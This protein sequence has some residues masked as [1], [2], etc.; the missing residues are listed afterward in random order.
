M[1]APSKL[2]PV[3]PDHVPTDLVFDFDIYADPRIDSD[4]QGSYQRAI[5]GAPDIFWTPANGGHWMVQRMDSI[6]AITTDPEHFSVREMQIPRVEN[7]PFMI[8]LSL[9]PPENLPYRRAMSPMFGPKA[10]KALEP[11]LRYWAEKIVDS[12]ADK[13][14]CD[15]MAEVAKIYPVSIFMELMGMDLARLPEFRDLAERFFDAQNNSAL[16]DQLS[17]QI[18]GILSEL[19][20]EKRK[21]PDEQLMSHFVHVD[22]GEGKPMSDNEILAMSFVLFLGGMDTVTNVTGFAFQQL[23]QMPDLQKPMAADPAGLSTAFADEAV[24][25]FGVINTPRLVVKDIDL[26]GVPFRTG[27]MVLN[28]LPVGSRDDR[29][30]E[31][32]NLLDIDRK[33]AAHI[34]FSTGPHLCIG[35]VLGRAE[36]RVMAEEWFKRIPSFELVPDSERTF[37]TGTVM[38]LENLPL[39][40]DS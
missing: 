33:R 31:H 13:G 7:P 12:V 32:P 25:A 28:V 19:I 4:V 30:F 22:M 10:I 2:A 21:N 23:A 37:R 15:F 29:K 5:N 17:A 40:W 26:L 36:I 16:L 1:N 8:P 11:R 6:A 24:R 35:H 14:E 38:A 9:D 34:T 3:I 39:R 20:E 18:L 27:D